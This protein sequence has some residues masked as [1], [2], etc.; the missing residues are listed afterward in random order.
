MTKLQIHSPG[1][2]VIMLRFFRH[3]RRKLLEQTKVASYLKYALGEILLVVV[4][5]LLALQQLKRQ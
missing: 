2:V 3:L 1:C 5:I 4:G